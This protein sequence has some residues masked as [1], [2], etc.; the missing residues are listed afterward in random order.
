MIFLVTDTETSDL[1]KHDLPPDDPSQP[2]ICA[3]AAQLR[4]DKGDLL[5]FFS[6]RIQSNSRPIRKEALAVHGISEAEAGR[7]GVSEAAALGMLIGFAAQA[8]D[9]VCH[10][11]AFERGM[12]AATLYRMNKAT[13]VWLRPRLRFHCTMLAAAPIC[14][15]PGKLENGVHKWP[16]LDEAAAVLLGRQ[17]RE[18][19]H[20]AWGDADLTWDVF[21]ALRSRGAI[22]GVGQ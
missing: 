8:T 14:R 5:D 1:P 19:H 17:P 20:R 6:T 22:E 15:L 7:Y 21:E 3:I 4:N 10:N 2:W 13:D 9:V 18:G 16:T 11:A 12:V